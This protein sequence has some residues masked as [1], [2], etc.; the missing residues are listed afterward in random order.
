MATLDQV[1]ADLRGVLQDDG[2]RNLLDGKQELYSDAQLQ[3]YVNLGLMDLQTTPPFETGF[4]IDQFPEPLVVLA[5]LVEVLKSEGLLQA[6]NQLTYND[7]GLSVGLYDK[8]MLFQSWF[9]QAKTQYEMAKAM[10]KAAW[11][12]RHPSSGF[13][14]ISSPFTRNPYFTQ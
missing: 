4:T 14:G 5:G 3:L 2:A 1:V 8:S 7:A 10:W 6:R 9:V 13:V 12:A 11:I